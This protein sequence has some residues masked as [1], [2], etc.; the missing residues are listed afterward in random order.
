MKIKTIISIFL[1]TLSASF[2]IYGQSGWQNPADRYKDAYKEYLNEPERITDSQISHFVYFARDREAIESHSFLGV[3][4]LEGAQIMYAW[5]QLEPEK[6]IYDFSLIEKDLQYLEKRGKKLFVQL[7]DSTFNPGRKAVPDYLLTSEYGGG[8]VKMINDD[9]VHEG[10]AAKKWNPEVQKRFSGL[11]IELGKQF[12]GRIEGINLQETAAAGG[13]DDPSFSPALYAEAIKRN[14]LAMKE[15]FS[16]STVMQYAN[17]MPGEWLPWEDEGYL[18]SIYAYGEQIGVGLGAPDLMITRRGQLN[19]ALAMM[20]EH[21]YSV[22]LGIA[23]QDGN[24]IGETGNTRVVSDRATIVPMLEG[25]AKGF[26]NVD[27]MFWSFQEPYFSEDVLPFF[28]P[29]SR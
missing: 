2:S 1:L 22:P 7:Q 13:S 15:G 16:R 8:A 26:L 28:N 20:H 27:Y 4:R 12:D 11:L 17:F 3:S 25:F 9:G 10:W 6:G 14:M 21:E 29:E 24:Y 23:V 18:R 5:K 19:H